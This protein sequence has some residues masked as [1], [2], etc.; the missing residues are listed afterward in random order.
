MS[1][2]S[3]TTGRKCEKAKV[4]QRLLEATSFAS[5]LVCFGYFTSPASAACGANNNPTY[6]A[7]VTCTTTNTNANLT[8]AGPS[9]VTVTNAPGTQDAIRSEVDGNTGNATATINNV[10]VVNNDN[11]NPS[12]GVYALV[13]AATAVGNG[14][15]TM[16]G[17]N[18][19]TTANGTV[20]LA[21]VRGTGSATIDISGT[22]NA[23]GL[24]TNTDDNDGIEATTHNGGAATINMAQA[25]G[26]ISVKGG[27][28]ILIDSLAGGGAVTGNIGSGMTIDLDNTIAGANGALN[29]NSGIFAFTQAAGTIDLTTGAT[30]NTLGDRADGIRGTAV[31]G[32]INVVNSGAITTVGANSRGI[33]LSTTAGASGPGGAITLT[34]SGDIVTSGAN[35][36]GILATSTDGNLSATNS[37]AIT[38]SGREAHGIQATTANAGTSTV[39]TD[40]A[41]AANGQLAIGAYALG[42]TTSVT[43]GAAGSVSGGWQADLAGVGANGLP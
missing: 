4:R 16:T 18:N 1:I 26:V 10:T 9:T 8:M 23:T 36:T 21:N 24:V 13:S 5:L 33:D 11:T 22:L 17:S 32:T 41:V 15:L 39:S 19:V 2:E 20:I 28:G 27:N 3:N 31:R 42:S 30:I 12:I 29:P 25:S 34:N 43:V 37:G 40:D 14:L 38:T 6:A 7:P 35:S